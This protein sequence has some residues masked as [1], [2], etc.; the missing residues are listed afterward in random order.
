MK[1]LNQL[2]KEYGNDP[3]YLKVLH[4]KTEEEYWYAVDTLISIRGETAYQNF[5]NRAKYLQEG[6]TNGC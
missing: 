5:K 1:V 3:L 4:A 6:E 2:K